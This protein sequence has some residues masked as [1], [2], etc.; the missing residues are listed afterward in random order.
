MK[1]NVESARAE[2]VIFSMLRSNKLKVENYEDPSHGGPGFICKS[3]SHSFL[4]EVSCLEVDSVAKNSGI[5]N[6]IPKESVAST[7]NL[8]TNL[9]RT[10]ASSKTK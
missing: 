4:V 2:A 3:N 7:Y 10:K 9:L 1:N 8:I 5:P 6:E